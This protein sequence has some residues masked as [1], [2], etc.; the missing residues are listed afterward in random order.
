MAATHLSGVGPRFPYLRQRLLE[1]A[2]NLGWAEVVPRLKVLLALAVRPVRRLLARG[3]AGV[4]ELP[5]RDAH[6]DDPA[7]GRLAG[8][9]HRSRW[10]PAGAEGHKYPLR[11]I[12]RAS[13]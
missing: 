1:H 3:L 13:S 4:T 7:V 9:G 10:T 6:E 5:L 11:L 8:F 12:S 2:L